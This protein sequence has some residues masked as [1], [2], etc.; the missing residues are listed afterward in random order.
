M[1]GGLVALAKVTQLSHHAT[2]D[3]Y[4]GKLYVVLGKSVGCEVRQMFQS[5]FSSQ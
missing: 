5:Q 3:L 4:L 1:I 2:L